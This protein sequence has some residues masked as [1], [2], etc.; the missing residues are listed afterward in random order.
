MADVKEIQ[1]EGA[2]F[3]RVLNIFFVGVTAV[4]DSLTDLENVCVVKITVTNDE[5]FKVSPLACKYRKDDVV[6]L[7][8]ENVRIITDV[9]SCEFTFLQF[10]NVYDLLREIRSRITGR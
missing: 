2:I 8:R 4:V 9:D 6:P 1:L 10:H 3:I 7:E 5:I